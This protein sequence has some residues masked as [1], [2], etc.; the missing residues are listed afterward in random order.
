MVLE[1]YNVNKTTES[2]NEYLMVLSAHSRE[3]LLEKVLNLYKWM[4]DEQ[5][6][7]FTLGSVSCTLAAIETYAYRIALVV[8]DKEEALGY[9]KA[10][11]DQIDHYMV[12]TNAQSKDSTISCEA[13][14]LL[15]ED[16]LNGFHIGSYKKYLQGK[17]Y[18]IIS[19]PPYPYQKEL[20]YLEHVNNEI[21]I[22]QQS[23]KGLDYHIEDHMLDGQPVLPGAALLDIMCQKQ[24]KNQ[25]NRFNTISNVCFLNTS[26]NPET[27]DIKVKEF[28]D[29]TAYSVYANDQQMILATGEI[30]YE[31]AIEE[32]LDIEAIKQ[33]CNQVISRTEC[34]DEFSKMG[35]A[36]GTSYRLIENIYYNQEETLS[37]LKHV[38]HPETIWDPSIIDAAFQSIVPLLNQE[39]EHKHRFAP[40]A[41]NQVSVYGDLENT[42]YV[43]TKCV[44]DLQNY[45]SQ[46]FDLELLDQKGIIVAVI[47]GFVRKKI[48]EGLSTLQVSVPEYKLA[49]SKECFSKDGYL[50]VMGLKETLYQDKQ[51]DHAFSGRV[52]HQVL[53]RDRVY[54]YKN[55]FT[56]FSKERK[57]INHI[58]YLGAFRASREQSSNILYSLTTLVQGITNRKNG[59]RIEITCV[60][61][62]SRSDSSFYVA[63]EGF[64]LS[65]HREHPDILLRTVN[66]LNCIEGSEEFYSS[67]SKEVL[68]DSAEFAVIYENGVRK[69][70]EYHTYRPDEILHHSPIKEGG[71]Y[72]ITGGLGGIGTGLAKYL[73]SVHNV[74]IILL[75]RSSVTPEQI[76]ECFETQKK[77]VYYQTDLG[78]ESSIRKTLTEITNR[79]GR[80][81]GIYHCAGNTRDCL[82]KNKQKEDMKVVLS[83]KV[84]GM[85][86]LETYLEEHPSCYLVC[87]SSIAAV[88]GNVGQT[89]YAYA[90]RFMDSEAQKQQNNRIYSYDWA[91]WMNGSMGNS[92][93]IRNKMKEDF[94]ILPIEDKEGFDML[95]SLL[96]C[97]I[98][99]AVITKGAPLDRLLP[100]L[101]A[102]MEDEKTDRKEEDSKAPQ[103]SIQAISYIEE[104]EDIAKEYFNNEHLEKTTCFEDGDL[105]SIS[106]MEFSSAVSDRFHLR[107]SVAS[108]F[109]YNTLERLAQ[110]ICE[111]KGDKQSAPN[112]VEESKEYDMFE[113]ISTVGLEEINIEKEKETVVQSKAS[114]HDVAVV[115]ISARFPGAKDIEAFWNNLMENK[116][117]IIETP[118][119]RWDIEQF[120]GKDQDYVRYGGF[121]D[122][123]KEFDSLYFHIS[124]AEAK[125]I[126]PQQRILLEETVNCLENAGIRAKDIEGKMISVYIG[127]FSS[128][129]MQ[130]INRS[131]LSLDPNAIAGNDHAM[132][133]N[134]ISYFFN[135]KGNSEAVDTACSS[136][137]AC[138]LKAVKEI[139]AGECEGAIVGG[140]NLM[141]D[142][143]GSIRVGRLGFLNQ[144]GVIKSFTDDADGYVRGEGVGVMYLKPLRKAK[145][146]GNR[147]LAIIK[148]GAA[149]HSGKGHYLMEPNTLQEAE[150]IKSAYKDAKVSFGTVNYIEAHGTGT[151]TGDENELYAY[152]KA[153]RDMEKETGQSF[154]KKFCGIG[155]VKP[156]IGHLEAA[157]GM[158][159]MIKLILALYNKQI[160]GMLLH[161]KATLEFELDKSY[162]YLQEKNTPWEMLTTTDGK[163]IP[164]RGEVH[165]YGYGGTNVHLIME[166]YI[167]EPYIEEAE[168]MPTTMIFPVS[169]NSENSLYTYVGK[170]QSLVEHLEQTQMKELAYS[171]QSTKEVFERRVAFVAK[172]KE[173]LLNLMKSYME[174]TSSSQI[175]T[176][177]SH[178]IKNFVKEVFGNENIDSLLAIL[179]DNGNDMGIA[180]LWANG[181]D[182]EWK[183]LFNYNHSPKLMLPSYPFDKK[184]YWLTED[185]QN[186]KEDFP[187]QS[188]KI[189]KDTESIIMLKQMLSQCLEIPAEQIGNSRKLDD[190]GFNSIMLA[191]FKFQLEEYYGISFRTV[192]LASK[193][194]VLELSEYINKELN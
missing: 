49:K 154:T 168:P 53:E 76:E 142:P 68:S 22:Q 114:E 47:R 141:L 194:T 128:D 13:L 62:G 193:E 99:N 32:Q 90:N 78:K 57:D 60:F 72:L 70:K 21:P 153:F 102:Q 177:N 58:L 79:Y 145:E 183:R 103:T 164:R 36:Y 143:A 148:G 9:L 2:L 81:D 59:K 151:K 126:D 67:I 3:A 146:D 16:Y 6:Q 5:N 110:Y 54:D 107:I 44:S 180:S 147:I 85:V 144:D 29:R 20:C 138:A 115:G 96:E 106:L 140:V 71:I 39:E 94:G 133:A 33:R 122:N 50:L 27:L 172:D 189:L 124:P 165:A 69:V 45:S 65:V 130:L 43:H 63:L 95:F 26:S 121:I 170:Y 149:N 92:T 14:S 101:S 34:Y 84:N 150:V 10:V 109:E 28:A 185:S 186:R 139:R 24:Q 91:L 192:E 181:L 83:P 113:R 80:I 190:M 156:N 137:L 155:T 100:R 120:D 25:E 8:R 123:V 86:S 4:S 40:Y 46:R 12:C 73:L 158:A 173:Q 174:G 187:Q 167:D 191:K 66:L 23:Q 11:S 129:Y 82:L 159:S 38:N 112:T 127:A 117:S 184:E 182:I 74:Q 135:L 178:E 166:E 98:K 77:P 152:K 17:G 119:E 88:I 169:A 171:M 108:L 55:L 52:I 42:V 132:M 35:L 64:A 18:G 104:L 31:N 7:E 75:G 97:G 105:D 30:R 111:E 163:P 157:S 19:L 41:V 93:Y 136:S 179:K 61:D 160:P 161:G 87:F 1:E 15:K 176:A 118:K 37:A 131:E 125:L 116:E 175:K 51:L 188:K 89:D 134:R 48:N 162:F 56:K